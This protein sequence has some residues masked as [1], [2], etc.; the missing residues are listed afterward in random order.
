MTLVNT[1]PCS[2]FVLEVQSG[3]F[4]TLRISWSASS[5]EGSSLVVSEMTS[6][7]WLIDSISVGHVLAIMP[8]EGCSQLLSHI[9]E[10]NLAERVA[11]STVPNDLGSIFSDIRF[12][13]DGK[14]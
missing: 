3:G 7:E 9:V 5:C 13:C 4:I 8:V 1:I 11:I 14:V 2:G 6:H 10:L 12:P